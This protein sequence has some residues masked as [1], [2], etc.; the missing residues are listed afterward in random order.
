MSSPGSSDFTKGIEREAD[1]IWGKLPTEI[2]GSGIVR[3]FMWPK[4][5]ERVLVAGTATSC[6]KGHVTLR[7]RWAVKFTHVA[8]P[9][10]RHDRGNKYLD[11]D[12][13]G[14]PRRT[15]QKALRK[16]GRRN[17]AEGAFVQHRNGAAA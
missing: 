10:D 3:L 9:S 16:R 17:L 15:I 11:P 8:R 7:T 6:D 14:R 1:H 2:R 5:L 4:L 12:G 13:P